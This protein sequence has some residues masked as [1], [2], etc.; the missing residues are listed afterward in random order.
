MSLQVAIIGVGLIGGSLAMAWKARGVVREIVGV[1]RR[2]KTIDEALAVG[3]I[4]WGTLSLE[5]GVKNA[6]VVVLATPVETIA[7]LYLQMEPHLKEGALVTDV[8]STKSELC[9]A[10]WSNETGRALFIGGHP[11]AGSEKEGVLAADPYLFENAPF[12]FVP[13]KVTSGSF[14]IEEGL[15]RLKLLAEAAGAKPIVMDA[16]SHDSVV[17]TVSHLPH[18]V[19][20]AL[21][22]TAAKEDKRIPN[23]LQ[24][25][26]GGFRDTTRIASGPEDVWADI[27]MTNSPQ[28]V[29]AIDRFDATLDQ[30]RQALIARDKEA[31]KALLRRSRDVRD[32]IPAKSKG[33]LSS[34]WDAVVH[35]VDRPGALHEVT[36]IIGDEGI[37]II[38]I[39]IMRVREGEGGTVR[40][41]FEGQDA[42]ERSVALLNARGYKARPRDL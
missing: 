30:F 36:G 42:M 16:E 40:L 34:V 13:P 22:Q 20:A 21:V 10:I 2:Q 37:N 15:N 4:D 25:A 9:H 35:V 19:A 17:A 39:E 11:M 23:L 24:L 3:A 29:A 7:P 12:V 31:L 28:I 33:I 41:G 6:D 38:D 14:Q 18:M 8:G 32:A 5:E 27:C 26:A 1:A